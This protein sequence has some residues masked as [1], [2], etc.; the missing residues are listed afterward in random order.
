[1]ND[2]ILKPKPVPKWLEFIEVSFP[3]KKT[4][5]FMVKN[6]DTGDWLGDIKWYGAWRKYSFFTKAIMDHSKPVQF[7]FEATC[8]QDITDFL[9]YLMQEWKIQKQTE[10]EAKEWKLT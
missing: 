10:K 9:N 6:K 5:T 7:V 4:K 2:K 1:M 3:D 8:L